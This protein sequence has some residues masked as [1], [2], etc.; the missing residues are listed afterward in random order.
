[1]CGI[2][3]IYEYATSQGSVRPEVVVAMRETLRHRGPDG[4]GL[5]VSPDRRVGLG[6]RRLAIVDPDHGRQPMFGANGECLV[7]NGE[8]YNYPRLRTELEAR[9]V[10]FATNCDTEVILHLY[11]LEGEG[12]LQRL[13]GMFA[14][15]IWDPQ[16]E[17][18]LLARDPIGEKPLYWTDVGGRIVFGSEIKALLRHPSVT[19]EVNETAI[20]PYLANLVSPSPETLFRGISKLPPGT[21]A[22][23]DSGG[24]RVSSYSDLPGPREWSSDSLPEAAS[25]VRGL[26]DRSIHDR[27]MSDVPVGVLL[28]GGLDSTTLVALLRDR[29]RD[30]A[31]FSVGF[32]GRPDIDE[33]D[34]ARRVSDHFG[35]DHHEVSI[36]E[37]DA[38]G[39]LPKLVHHQDEPL[40]DPVCVPLHFVCELAHDRGVKVVLAGEGADELFWGYPRYQR[41]LRAWPILR[42]LLALPAPARSRLPQLPGMGSHPQ[43]QELLHGVATG[44]LNPMH[45]PLGLTAGQREQLL[46]G[47][48][49]DLNLPPT[50]RS[51][52]ARQRLAFDT[53]E[54]EFQVRLP[55]LLLMRIDRFSMASS[56]EA[57]VPF[58]SPDLVRYVYGLPPE[59][60]LHHNTTKVVLR[61]AIKDVVPE[62]VL[63][64]PKQ[65][66]GA[67]IFEWMQSR[68]G[69]LLSELLEDRAIGQYFNIREVNRL[70]APGKAAGSAFSTWPILNFALWHRHWIQGEDLEPVVERL[71][72]PA[73]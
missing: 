11:G 58:L 67:P 23:C 36:S 73:A 64:R 27:L 47:P 59:L 71:L 34:D 8:I 41:V 52:T 42:T 38:I 44:R 31:T 3:G 28:S 32:E 13:D 15:V 2:A 22:T 6:H 53:Q 10:R 25:K 72:A 60:K 57:R 56:V 68:S 14:L 39:F 20:A 45:F 70:L 61:E 24:I 17:R 9:G 1:M 50:G 65:G 51:E 18:L 43:A 35:T 63:S 37:A 40:A 55:E 49:W 26:L 19:A 21:L 30:M 66:F 48:G 12:F 16:R 7:F 54:Y 46:A 5:F 33:R 69:A 4:E 29:A 62:S